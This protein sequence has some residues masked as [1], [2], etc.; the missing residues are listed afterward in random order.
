MHSSWAITMD[1]FMGQNNADIASGRLSPTVLSFTS[2]PLSPS[3]G[4]VTASLP[5]GDFPQ[6]TSQTTSSPTCPRCAAMSKQPKP[7]A[8]Y[9]KVVVFDPYRLEKPG[10]FRLQSFRAFMGNRLFGVVLIDLSPAA[11]CEGSLVLSSSQYSADTILRA[12]YEYLG[13][14]SLFRQ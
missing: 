13:S 10:S 11:C 12:L 14:H 1:L 7:W 8:L 3:F 4:N 6:Q 2:A 5:M 9:N